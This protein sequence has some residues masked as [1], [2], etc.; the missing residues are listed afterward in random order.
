MK[1]HEMEKLLSGKG[2]TSSIEQIGSLQHG[3]MPS[4]TPH[5]IDG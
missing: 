1:L 3:E 4:A 5:L 2:H